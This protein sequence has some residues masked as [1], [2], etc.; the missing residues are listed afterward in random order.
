MRGR[1][2]A[3]DA[4]FVAY[5]AQAGI[6]MSVG[7]EARLSGP[8]DPADLL[9]VLDALRAHWPV[10]G[11]R[12]ARGFVG[13]RWRPAFAAADLVRPLDS[14]DAWRNH[15]IDPFEEPPFQVAHLPTGLAFRAHHAALDGQALI[16]VTATLVRLLAARLGGQPAPPLPTGRPWRALAGPRALL[17]GARLRALFGYTRWLARE[18]RAGRSARLALAAVA[19]G[20]QAVTTGAV[21][22][23]PV[24]ARAHALGVS[25]AA[26]GAAAWVRAIA[27]FNA[28]R[29]PSSGP[30]SLEIP[31]SLRQG[32]ADAG[33]L[34][35]LISPLTV[36]ADAAQAL[37]E[38]A[39]ALHATLADAR[40]RR[41]HHA[42]PLFALPGAW[43][44]WWLFR[45]VAV[46]PTS[47]GF[48]TSHFTLLPPPGDLPADVEA[49]SG[50]RLRLLGRGMWTPVC[51][52]MGAALL[53]MPWGDAL[54]LAVTHRLTGLDA[55]A[56]EAL[57]AL[58]AEELAA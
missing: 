52:A 7:A 39:T 44:P 24:L 32:E 41:L 23:A 50:G 46:T 36:F 55:P 35:N 45:R 19:P 18:A 9:A 54:H 43:L 14:L 13:L 34:G 27:R 3:V 12:L 5:Q 17:A 57:V 2:S 47:T 56:A 10:L 49:L 48:A 16:V 38:V 53:A 30:I 29:L 15:P 21:P 51:L 31:V 40:A 58:L 26:L 42:V 33:L 37:P 8:A 22:L 25:P 6:L 1:L 4:F 28:A 20:P 11:C